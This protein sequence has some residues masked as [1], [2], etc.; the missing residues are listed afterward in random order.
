MTGWWNE[1]ADHRCSFSHGDGQV[2]LEALGVGEGQ[3]GHGFVVGE[4]YDQCGVAAADCTGLCCRC[5]FPDGCGHRR[6]PDCSHL[7]A[8]EGAADAVEMGDCA[9]EVC[10]DV[11]Y[12]RFCQRDRDSGSEPAVT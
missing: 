12:A 11:S 6:C 10:V 9:C 3:E 5:D 1:G 8:P 4:L 7:D 2:G